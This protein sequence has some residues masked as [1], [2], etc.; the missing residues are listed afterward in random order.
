MHIG[1]SSFVLDDGRSGIA[2]YIIG[3]LNGLQKV[4][5]ENLYEILSVQEQASLIPLHQNNFSLRLQNQFFHSP[6]SN[7]FWH[8]FLLPWIA[9]GSKYDLVHIPTIRRIPI[10]KGCKMIATV[11]DMAPFIIKN[12][13]GRIRSY[14]HHAILS[15]SIHRCDRLIAVSQTTKNDIVR[16]T[17]YSEEK[18]D[19]IYS[20]LD[21]FW[22]EETDPQ[23]R[24]QQLQITSPY[25]V[26]VSRL[27]HPAKNHISLISAFEKFKK[28]TDAPHQLI[29]AGAD[30]IGAEKI[31]ER[32]S[33]SA[34]AK[35][36]QCLGYIDRESVK[37]LYQGSHLMVF[38]SLYE[39]FGFP[40]IEAFACGAKVACANI[41]AFKEIASSYA[42]FFNPYDVKEI[43]HSLETGANKA[44]RSEAKAYA[45]SFH[46]EN[47][48][49]QVLEAYQKAVN[50]K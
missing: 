39:G 44:A 16:F 2:T 14:Y 13:Y 6:I 33:Q 49:T 1:F 47:T 40:I 48:A 28:R 12:K 15:R 4:D 42:S 32:I 25:F 30:W 8:N 7:I 17:G 18:I 45:A 3:L 22:L 19:V 26:Y 41:P 46:W 50:N 10:V 29:F 37:A 27:E 11:H 9:I 5:H 34:F 21:P 35:E 43:V 31:H 23:D 20:G 24:L 36:I 38:P